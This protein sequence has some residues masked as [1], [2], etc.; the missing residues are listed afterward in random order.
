MRVMTKIMKAN[1]IT[2]IRI[3]RQYIQIESEGQA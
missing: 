1:K 3:G 2:I